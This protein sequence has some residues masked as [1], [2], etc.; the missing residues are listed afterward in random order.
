MS[1]GAVLPITMPGT[2][3]NGA[4]KMLPGGAL[5]S[6]KTTPKWMSKPDSKLERGRTLHRTVLLT[7]YLTRVRS[8]NK[9]SMK[10]NEIARHK[11]YSKTGFSNWKPL[12]Q[13]RLP[14]RCYMF[15]PLGRAS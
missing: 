8:V 13:S 12:E 10:Q 15:P 7:G 2:F 6:R 9:A 3:A 5:H 11:E 14:E 4:N 1:S